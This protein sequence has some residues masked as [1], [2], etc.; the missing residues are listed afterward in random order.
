MSIGFFLLK[1]YAGLGCEK[2]ML[3]TNP[4][5]NNRVLSRTGARTLT[6]EEIAQVGGARNQTYVFTHVNFDDVT[7]D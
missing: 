2:E 4:S 3:M 5:D 6:L 1:G 7:R